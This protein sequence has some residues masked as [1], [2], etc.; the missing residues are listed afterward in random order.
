MRTSGHG[1]DTPLVLVTVGVAILVGVYL[2]GGPTEA[3]RAVNELVRS[4]AQEG[5][6]IFQ[7]L[8]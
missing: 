5:L 4:I 7:G 2:A 8:R 3:L 6:R 1:N